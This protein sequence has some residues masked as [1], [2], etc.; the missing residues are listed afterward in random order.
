MNTIAAYLGEKDAFK[1]LLSSFKA[2][3]SNSL[4]EAHISVLQEKSFQGF[5]SK[6]SPELFNGKTKDT[7]PN[8]GLG[9][10]LFSEPSH[11][12]DSS[13]SSPIYYNA[14]MGLTALFEGEIANKSVL[15]SELVQ[16]GHWP[17]PSS[18]IELFIELV[19]STK[20]HYSCT[21]LE[22]VEITSEKVMGSLS[23]IIVEKD[24]HEK[25]IVVLKN[26]SLFLSETAEG[27]LVSN[28]ASS[29]NKL[30]SS[31]NQIL[32]IDNKGLCQS[33][34]IEEGHKKHEGSGRLSYS[35]SDNKNGFAHHM[36]K[37]LHEIPSLANDLKKRYI[38]SN[39]LQI[40]LEIPEETVT[41]I[42]SSKRIIIL[43]DPLVIGS[44]Q[45]IK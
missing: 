36:L 35:I 39:D 21:L 24:N 7:V 40:Q 5:S 41:R 43:C 31:N 6:S 23:M 25:L 33:L 37:E 32:T 44:A 8:G 14:K 28:S 13:D 26:A 45:L 3:E 22:A 12:M 20:A 42:S 18:D 2:H 30:I 4:A 16:N 38:K 27:I 11:K 29:S 9:L 1:T 10:A 34:N 19:Q 17:I 15:Q